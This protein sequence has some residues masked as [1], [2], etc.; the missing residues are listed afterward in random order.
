LLQIS[1][2]VTAW[3]HGRKSAFV[4]LWGR[5][6]AGLTAAAAALAVLILIRYFFFIYQIFTHAY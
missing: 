4:R 5:D 2:P 3:I 1:Q 6:P